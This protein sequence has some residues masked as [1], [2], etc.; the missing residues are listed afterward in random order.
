MRYKEVAVI[1]LSTRFAGINNKSEFRDVLRKKK[2]MIGKPSI[3]RLDLMRQEHDD[4]YVE[5][6]YL[7]NIDAFDNAFFDI[8]KREARLMSPQQ[9]ICLEMAAEAVLDA[10][11]SLKSIKGTNC[12]IYIA[13]GESD[14]N[15]YVDKQSSSSIIG[16]MG[17]M[18]SGQIGYHLDLHGE[19]LTVSSGCSSSLLAIHTAC[20]KLTLSEIDMALVGGIILEV[21]VPKA[22]ENTYDILGIMSDDYKIHSFDEKANG[23]VSGEGGGFVLLKSLERAVKDGDHIYGVLVSG[24]VNGDGARCTN[25][26]M[27]SVEAQGDVVC[28]AWCDADI[29]KLTE[30]EAHGIGAPVGDAVEAQSLIDAI[31]K[32]KLEKNNVKISSVKSNIGHLFTLSGMASLI[33]TMI[34]YE[35]DET[36]PIASLEKVNPLIRFEDA[37]LEP[38][39]EVYHWNSG[40]ERM[41]GI[42]A[43]GLSGCNAHVVVKNYVGAKSNNNTIPSII[44]LSAKSKEAFDEWKAE[45]IESIE[46]HPEDVANLIYTLNVGRDDYSFRTAIYANNIT[47]KKNALEKANPVEAGEKDYQI[48]YAIKTEAEA[49]GFLESLKSIIPNIFSYRKKVTGASNIDD[50][51]A[52]FNAIREIGIKGKVK[53][54]DRYMATA[55]KCYDG[56]CGED[57]LESIKK[58]LTIDEDYSGFLKEIERRSKDKETIVIDFSKHGNIVVEESDKLKVFHVQKPDDLAGV[59]KFWYESG[60]TVEWDKMY[61]GEEYTRIP[62]PLYPFRKK[63][64]WIEVKDNEVVADQKPEKAKVKEKKVKTVQDKIVFLLSSENINDVDIH[65]YPYNNPDFRKVFN[66]ETGNISMDSQL[67]MLKKLSNDGIIPNTILADKKG[68]AVYSYSKGHI[69]KKRLLEAADNAEQLEQKTVIDYVKEAA[70]DAPVTVIDFSWKNRLSGNSL[71]GNI[72]IVSAFDEA[73]INKYLQDPHYYINEEV[74]VD[75]AQEPKVTVSDVHIKAGTD[76]ASKSADNASKPADVQK[77]KELTEAESFLE[78]TWAKAF[79]L[80]GA[81]GHDEDF[82]ALG[83]NSLIMQ[84]MSSEINDYFGKKFDIFEIYDYETI[85]KLAVRILED[86]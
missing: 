84:A 83:G 46:K 25:V 34:G 8:T 20:E 48:I 65:S 52:L 28:K 18:L 32:N 27:P 37:N 76:D 54:F 22:K 43:F 55:L 12:G 11:Y 23:T 67:A 15:S 81:I 41:T 63:R 42:S 77:S 53:L 3:E 38:L 69:S 1:G 40:E 30:V 86:E 14:Y 29:K 60:Q 10:G 4:N 85:E 39:Q 13:D 33:K 36:Y 73:D 6:G 78:K 75:D 79:N 57:E 35:N 59:I 62:A 82:F 47:D 51:L 44:K 68:K 7:E 56:K 31:K 80:D 61:S 49:D 71:P 45:I 2:S 50:I 5:C 17:F 19:N 74:A 26:S 24:A 9:R 72:H 16:S 70:Q 58:E 64:F 66:P 21:K